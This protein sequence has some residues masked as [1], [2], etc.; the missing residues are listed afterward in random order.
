MKYE[1]T[2]ISLEITLKQLHWFTGKFQRTGSNLQG[3]H[4]A[5]LLKK[6]LSMPNGKHTIC[7][8]IFGLLKILE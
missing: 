6:K 7:Y 1:A 8:K 4:I 2:Y 3:Q 5:E